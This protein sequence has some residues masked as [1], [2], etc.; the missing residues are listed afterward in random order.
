MSIQQNSPWEKFSLCLPYP[1]FT[2]YSA[3]PVSK[4]PD[5]NSTWRLTP[6]A[7]FSKSEPSFELHSSSLIFSS[8]SAGQSSVE[9][10]LSNNSQYARARRSPSISVAW[11]SEDAP[12]L[13]QVW[14]LIYAIFTVYHDEE[15]IRLTL[16]GR[17]TQ[18]IKDE[19]VAA[20]LAIAHPV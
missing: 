12:T 6:V 7:S 5:S 16:V 2:R 1:Y 18:T 3:A 14:L 20:G 13:A 19:L 4:Q 11:T 15:Q 8:I 17:D 9:L 10:P